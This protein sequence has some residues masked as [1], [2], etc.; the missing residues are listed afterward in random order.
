MN[1]FI[2]TLKIYFL[3]LVT[4]GHLSTDVIE[5]LAARIRAKWGY[6]HS[7]CVPEI[8]SAASLAHHGLLRSVERM[9]LWDVDLSSVPAE[10]LASLANCVTGVVGIGNVSN[11][12]LISFLDRSKSEWLHISNES[13]STAET[14]A[15]VRAMANVARVFLGSGGE[16]TLDMST[17]VTYD[18]QGRC[19]NLYFWYNTYDKY[20]EDVQRWL[21]ERSS[22]N[23]NTADDYCDITFIE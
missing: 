18:G 11:T 13:L 19:D 1:V 6:G 4:S 9:S 2:K 10:H 22:W 20:R 23:V 12:D 15:L 17:L 7:P 5:S 3:I 21:A 16:V 14:Q 8:T